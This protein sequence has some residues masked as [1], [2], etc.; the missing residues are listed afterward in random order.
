MTKKTINDITINYELEG[1]GKTIVFVHGLSDSL[2]YWKA[3][4]FISIAES[5]E[6][7][8]CCFC[9]AFIRWK[10]HIGLGCKS[11]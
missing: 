7:R 9:R 8:K 11:S 5:L 10:C 3:R 1:E 6:Y 2:A 4:G